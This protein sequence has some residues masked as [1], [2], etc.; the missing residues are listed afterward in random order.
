[1]RPRSLF[2]RAMA[3]G[4]D[5]SGLVYTTDDSGAPV[6]RDRFHWVTCEALATSYA[7][8]AT[9]GDESYGDQWRRLWAHA[10]EMF[11]D[12]EHGGWRHEIDTDGNLGRGTWTGKPDTYHALQAVLLPLLPFGA[13]FAGAL[14]DHRPTP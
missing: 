2:D 10:N 13:S 4:W 14:R 8:W 6:V 1:M 5:G 9:T 11:V 7:L 12:R 3:E